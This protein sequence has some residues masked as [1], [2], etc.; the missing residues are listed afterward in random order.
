[1]SPDPTAHLK[2]EHIWTYPNI[3]SH[4]ESEHLTTCDEQ[5]ILNLNMSEHR[6]TCHHILS[7]SGCKRIY[8]Y[9]YIYIYIYGHASAKPSE[10]DYDQHAPSKYNTRVCDEFNLVIMMGA[11]HKERTSNKR[12]KTSFMLNRR[13]W[14]DN[15][16]NASTRGNEERNG[17]TIFS[18]TAV[19]AQKSQQSLNGKCW[20]IQPRTSPL[21]PKMPCACHPPSPQVLWRLYKAWKRCQQK[22]LHVSLCPYI[23][24]VYLLG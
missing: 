23:P 6:S 2:S 21:T 8:T 13:S 5:Y 11:S 4:L 20:L 18:D 1:M 17:G 12:A 22:A 9:I 3:T 16:N 14:Q 19:A 7:G 15:A 24:Q 10:S